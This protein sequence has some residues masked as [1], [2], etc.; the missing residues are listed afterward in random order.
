MKHTLRFAAAMLALNGCAAPMLLPASPGLAQATSAPGRAG[1]TLL[2]AMPP[3][4]AG[5][6]GYAMSQGMRALQNFGGCPPPGAMQQAEPAGGTGAPQPDV[7]AQLKVLLSQKNACTA[8][9]RARPEFAPVAGHFSPVETGQFT[10]VQLADTARPSASEARLVARYYD[11]SSPCI[12]ALA[13]SFG[14]V[15]PTD[16][17]VLDQSIAAQQAV[18]TQL[19]TRRISWGEFA[20][21]SQKISEQA[22]AKFQTAGL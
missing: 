1:C 20:Q 19:A 2:T 15:S 7:A 16:G 11:A 18:V 4:Q 12:A 21:A 6:F 5:G 9:V 14:K 22:A 10:M 3:G 8:A 13:A 17:A